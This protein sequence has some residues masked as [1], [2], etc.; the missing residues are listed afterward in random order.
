MSE[1]KEVR[2]ARELNARRCEFSTRKI[3]LNAAVKE[4]DVQ[5]A[6]VEAGD[7][8]VKPR[9]SELEDIIRAHAEWL[10]RNAPLIKVS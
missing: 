9:V 2:E 3:F 7:L 5:R 10:E 8:S 6:K 4:L 1:R